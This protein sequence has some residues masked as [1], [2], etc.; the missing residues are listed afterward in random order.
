[1]VKRALRP[2]YYEDLDRETCK[3]LVSQFLKDL[4]SSYYRAAKN[5]PDDSIF[6]NQ[7]KEELM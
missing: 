3:H 4:E 5:E 7:A 1:M 6:D 2:K